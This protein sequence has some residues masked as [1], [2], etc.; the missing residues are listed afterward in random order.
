MAPTPAKTK[1]PRQKPPT[2]E[3]WAT[4][5][6]FPAY[7][8]SNL[9]NVR[10]AD[11]PLTRFFY[12]RAY[13]VALSVPR[14]QAVSVASLVTEAFLGLPSLSLCRTD[15]RIIHRD[16]DLSNCRAT[17]LLLVPRRKH[18]KI[19]LERAR[20]LRE[21]GLSS[22]F[23][24]RITRVKPGALKKYRKRRRGHAEA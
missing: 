3:A 8:V 6:S 16:G 17:N 4:C 24:E 5:P 2:G 9:G 20:K 10:H 13:R 7:Q 14:Q 21:D 11:R 22:E 15:F 19:D 12:Q 18:G 1:K 23:T